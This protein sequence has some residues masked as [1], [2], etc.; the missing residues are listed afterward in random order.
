MLRLYGNVASGHSYKIRLFLLLAGIEHEYRE[1]DLDVPHRQRAADFVAAS[2]FGEVPV[3][4]IDGEA[5]CQSNAIL[6]TLAER[7]SHFRGTD[8]EWPTVLE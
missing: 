1:V 8:A 2:R 6:I 4:V 7:Y 3:V 5:V